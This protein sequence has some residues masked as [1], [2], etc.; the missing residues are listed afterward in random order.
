MVHMLCSAILCPNH[1][2]K[3]D[4]RCHQHHMS[5]DISAWIP[6]TG[7]VALVPEAGVAM[8]TLAAVTLGRTQTDECAPGAGLQTPAEMRTSGL[9]H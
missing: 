9:I 2:G 3:L 5:M 7:I 6:P 4:M 8:A 1:S